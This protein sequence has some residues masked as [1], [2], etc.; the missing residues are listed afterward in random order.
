MAKCFLRLCVFSVSR[1]SQHVTVQIMKIWKLEQEIW[2]CSRISMFSSEK[3]L[4]M[5]L[6]MK[7]NA[8]TSVN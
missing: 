8:A 2:N 7:R 3:D 1:T 5:K 6:N 4:V